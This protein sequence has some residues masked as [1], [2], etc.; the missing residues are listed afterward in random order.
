MHRMPFPKI[1][2]FSLICLFLLYS[3]LLGQK[4]AA[5]EVD[6]A[7]CWSYSLGDAAGEQIV[8]DGNQV[9]LGLEG[10]KAEALSLDGRKIW[11][12]EFGGQFK[13]NILTADGGLF[14][15]NL[16]VSG[17]A[18]KPGDSKLRSIS[19]ETGITNWT[20]PMPDASH[21]WLGKFNGAVIIVAKN[22]IIQSVDAKNGNMKW[23]RE[24]PDGFVAEPLF[25][26]AGVFVA[27]T[28]N[29]IF[30]I[31]MKAGEIL[32]VRK[33]R[34]GITSLGETKSG[35]LIAG[36]ERGN[37]YSLDGNGK[38]I[39]TFKAGGQI[40]N[41]LASSDDFLVASHDNF[42]YFLRGRNGGRVWKLRL[43]GRV[44]GTTL[45]AG[46]YALISSFEEHRAMVVDLERGRI[47][48]QAVFDDDET[49]VQT[50]PHS[51]QLIFVLTNKALNAYSV[52]GC[53]PK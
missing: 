40:S 53:P 10:A 37:V 17:D 47:A 48:G 16:T 15:V 44:T 12:S 38:P 43:P 50:W 13:S 19:K 28:G 18:T 8:S 21:Y 42:V 34:F 24:I 30:G 27:T 22:G 7:K 29:Q 36:D 49:T 45:Y 33:V 3:S 41:I 32:S 1:L 20:L 9:L 26:S 31:S 23:K 46:S 39:W 51:E 25:N 4:R 35:E 5:A 2:V 14:L 6:V 52:S 11:S